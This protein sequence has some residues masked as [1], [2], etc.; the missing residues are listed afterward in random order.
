MLFAEVRYYLSESFP[1]KKY[2][3]LRKELD[4]NGAKC[5]DSLTNC[6][7]VITDSSVFEG[8]KEAGEN[9]VV[10]SDLW[11]TR[12][13]T[14]GKLQDPAFYSADPGM[15]F[16]G[17][18]ACATN[19]LPVDLEVL[20]AGIVALGGQ[21]RRQYTK[22]ATHLFTLHDGS[23][24]YQ[25]AMEFQAE[26]GMKIV[27]P[28]WFDDSVKLGVRNLDTSPYEWPDPLVLK[29]GKQKQQ[30]VVKKVKS[31]DPAK[32]ALFKTAAWDSDSDIPNTSGNAVYGGRRVLL[33]RTLEL[34]DRIVAV[35]SGIRRAGGK[36]VKHKK[37]EDELV[38]VD[39]C[40]IFIT[41]F[42]GGAGYFKAVKTGKTIGTLQWLFHV[43][44][45]GVLTRPLDQLLHYPYPSKPIENFTSHQ[46]TISN[47]TGEAREYLKRLI[48]A[49]GAQFTPTMSNRNTVLVAAEVHN[50]AKA[51]RA[52]AW[53]IPIVNH[54]WLEDC[55]VQWRNLTTGLEKYLA[56]PP[57]FDFYTCLGQR[58][59]SK[60]VEDLEEIVKAEVEE[61]E[62]EL[63]VLGNDVAIGIPPGTENSARDATEVANFIEPGPVDVDGGA[64]DHD[65]DV[66]GP[67]TPRT[68]PM[69]LAK[70]P[71]SK[72]ASKQTKTLSSRSHRKKEPEEKA[73]AEDDEPFE[74][75][76]SKVYGRATRSRNL[77]SQEDDGLSMEVDQEK[78]NKVAQVVTR[79]AS[80]SGVSKGK[81]TLLVSS[82]DDSPLSSPPQKRFPHRKKIQIMS[83]EWRSEDEL[84]P[85]KSSSK[86]NKGEGSSR[87]GISV[88][89]TRSM[90]DV[91]VPTL[92]SITSPPGQR[93]TKSESIHVAAKEQG[94]RKRNSKA[95]IPPSSPPVS[96][97]T[98]R[99]KRSAATKATEK[100][101]NQV[102]PDVLSY[103]Q[104]LKNSKTKGGRKSLGA[105]SLVDEPHNVRRASRIHSAE[106]E[107]ESEVDP[108]STSGKL[109]KQK[110]KRKFIDAEDE[111]ERGLVKSKKGKKLE[112]DD[113]GEEGNVTTATYHGG[114]RKAGSKIDR[115]RLDKVEVEETD[116]EISSRQ[117]KRKVEM[118][119]EIRMLTTQVTLRDEV[120]KMLFKLG[121][122]MAM[123][124]KPW[125]CTHLIV[126]SLVRTEKFLCAVA[127]GAY[128]VSEKWA[129]ECANARRLLPEEKYILHDP[130]GEAKYDM[131]LKVSLERARKSKEEKNRLLERHIFYVT[132]RVPA[133]VKMLKNVV[134]ACGGQ[135]TSQTPTPRIIE[136]SPA[137]RHVIS[138]PEDANVWGPIAQKGHKIY[139]QEL[140]LTGVLRQEIEWGNEKWMVEGSF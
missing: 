83:N 44:S 103:Q 88:S 51:E 137:M 74:K 86:H 71:A 31:S 11:A 128:I 6:T 124:S 65:M 27:T 42:R 4:Q 132:H 72:S 101:H 97:A 22:D 9:M 100:L 93:L 123:A 17:I 95:S 67:I 26:S 118:M 62:A 119:T 69:K 45:T 99:V 109:Q 90:V 108:P 33:S 56:H 24:D 12:S 84:S 79:K 120:S 48:A 105:F 38:K 107:G 130:E 117:K 87:I 126:K 133:D 138:C 30:E 96:S 29:R 40:D 41:R 125:D 98:T 39:E 19:L 34:G 18:I 59:V 80:N 63:V 136:I 73:A 16:S 116:A 82:D 77:V 36:V 104:Q 89:P 115:D 50:G 23:I 10:V 8:Y 61:Q 85:G 2:Q 64:A 15:I 53:S 47:Y 106:E 139:T 131:N 35:E 75:R 58:G 78:E 37:M 91:V 5:V 52:L 113:E 70:S 7:H 60:A 57:G 3:E 21:W 127:I 121:V 13:I 55:F 134:T 25:N 81:V 20:S 1:T 111:V 102:M 76:L 43:Q 92:Q 140:L 129:I 110:G 46:I 68:S 122:K 135:F 14:L 114:K 66:D 32:E 28:H 94:N 112:V 49:M 54:L